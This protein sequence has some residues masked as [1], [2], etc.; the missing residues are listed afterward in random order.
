MRDFLNQILAF[1]GATSLTDEEFATFTVS[2]Q[3]YDET[4]Y[5]EIQTLLIDRNAVS[6]TRDRLKYMFLA[7]GVSVGDA[8]ASGKSNILVGGVLE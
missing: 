3:T 6:G 8:L 1:I 2:T 7:R 4:L 5:T